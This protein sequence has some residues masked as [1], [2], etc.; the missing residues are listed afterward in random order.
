MGMDKLM[1][2]GIKNVVQFSLYY[3]GIYVDHIYI[4]IY[5]YIVKNFHQHSY[6]FENLMSS[7]GVGILFSK[8]LYGN[9]FLKNHA[10]SI[11]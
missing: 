11:G 3:L 2:R 7:W 9:V 5:I 6:G 10:K 1:G 8:L 4:Y